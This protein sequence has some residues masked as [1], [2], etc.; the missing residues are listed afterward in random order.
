MRLTLDRVEGDIA[1]FEDRDGRMREYPAW[2]L[3]EGSSD[4]DV[5]EAGAAPWDGYVRLTPVAGET[6]ERK[7]RISALFDELKSKG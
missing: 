6:E 7:K 1:I 2:V 4:G 5:F 3:P